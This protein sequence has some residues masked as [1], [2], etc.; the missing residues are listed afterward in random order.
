M[1]WESKRVMA[2]GERAVGAAG[3]VMAA[4]TGDHS[5]ASYTHIEN[6]YVQQASRAAV[7]SSEEA[8]DALRRYATRVRECYGR[9]DLEVLI[10]T[11]EGEH[12]PVVLE[13]VFVPPVVR[14]NPPPVELPRDIRQRLVE[15]GEWPSSLPPG[16]EREALDRARQE[17]AERPARDVLEVLADP[18]A[19]RVVLLGDPGAGKST[20]ARYLALLLPG[21]IPV[22]HPLESLVGRVPLV[23]ELREY[24]A[25]GWRDRTFEEFLRHLHGTKG[26][27]PPFPVTERLLAEGRAVVV[28]DG[29]DELFDPAAR[30]EVSHRI[31]DFAFRYTE[32]GVRVVVTSRVIGY[33]HGVLERAGFEHFKI[34]DLDEVRIDEFARQWYASACPQDDE[35]AH[36][37]YARLTGAVTQSRSLKG[38]AG[39]PLLLTI[40]AI[41]GRR[42]ELPRDRQG[43]YR[44]AIAVLVAH[45][46]QQAKNLHSPEDAEALAYLGDEDRQ[47]LLCLVARRIQEGTDSIESNYIHQDEL[48]AIF[49]EYLREQ[50]ELPVAQAVAAARTMVKQLRERNFIL[51]HYG[52]GTYAFVH[53]TF[54]EYLAAEDIGRRYTREREWTPEELIDEVFVRRADDPAWHEVLLLLIGQLGDRESAAA[55]DRLLEMHRR[56]SESDVRRLVLATRALTEV[57]KIGTVASQSRAVVDALIRC[58][59][60]ADTW[61]GLS[62][63]DEET[64][65]ALSTLPPHWSGRP[66]FLRWFH[67]R[68]QFRE[69]DDHPGMMACVL[70]RGFELPRRMSV[71]ARSGTARSW[72]L[73]FLTASCDSAAQI[74]DL[75]RDP[76]RKD[77]DSDV[78]YT[79]LFLLAENGG[80]GAEVRELIRDRS[81]TDPAIWVRALALSLRGSVGDD[82]WQP[83]FEAAE[84]GPDRDERLSA[85]IAIAKYRGDD[86]RTWR[87]LRRHAVGDPS[88]L[89][90]EA[91]LAGLHDTCSDRDDTWALIRDRAASD[92]QTRVRQ[93]ALRLLG[94]RPD[95]W[96]FVRGLALSAK[97]SYIRSQALDVL[98]QLRGDDP[99]TWQLVRQRTVD[100]PNEHVRGNACSLLGPRKDDIGAEDL[101]RRRIAE[102]PG[103]IARADALDA[104]SD[105]Y[106]DDEGVWD[107]ARRLAVEDPSDGVRDVAITAL[108]ENRSEDPATWKLVFDRVATDEHAFVRE[109]AMRS[110]RHYPGDRGHA[111]NLLRE[112]AYDDS[113]ASVRARAL[114]LLATDRGDE[115]ATLDVIR[116][117]AV[118][119]P[120][121][122][123]RAAA[124]RWWAVYEKGEAGAELLRGRAV[125]DPHPDARTV[126]LQSLAYGWPAHPAT[127]PLLRER[128]EADKDED[129]RAAAARS[130]V[131]AEALA[132][133]ADQLP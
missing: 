133:L 47:E 29:L 10:P 107:L 7:L 122:R 23:V 69:G 96:E 106:G 113:D 132:P 128:A 56:R 67:L 78:R 91:A 26:M 6:Q 126:A 31:A 100:D 40:L 90:R 129:V 80:D 79:A 131:A 44:H 3:D 81:R 28:F 12:P 54:L 112:R 59:E 76:V 5:N 22:G 20:L 118:A 21:E 15:A 73:R 94:R 64:V 53:R 95:D 42:R 71:H 8:A 46:D 104:L 93:K 62:L 98:A 89:I 60:L 102:D 57:R 38:L 48:L 33:L 117:R 35:L 68:G 52:A 32:A 61:I 87:V 27:A 82:A 121:A 103:E 14:A 39:N 16:L 108:C 66:R 72:L 9:L 75:L 34:E 116:D 111:W 36:R 45:W 123:V 63:W 85:L 49:K 70:Y 18:E 11:E 30:K 4:A 130:L 92:S 88:E 125:T 120:A 24:A 74:Y 97:D 77:P 86:P 2:A 109:E 51:G 50:Y 55:I 58:L 37:L 119:D 115:P 127:I 101:L 124:L 13:E 25:A 99:D 17:Y 43:V 19:D 110:M 41:V 1:G 83:I 84:S 65:L 114:L 105:N